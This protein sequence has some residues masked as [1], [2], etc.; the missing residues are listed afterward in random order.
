MSRRQ[1]SSA[2]SPTRST[3]EQPSRSE[4][5]TNWRAA[6]VQRLSQVAARLGVLPQLMQGI[7]PI[8]GAPARPDVLSAVE[9]SLE[10]AYMMVPE[11][12]QRELSKTATQ[13]RD[14]NQKKKALA[15]IAGSSGS[16]ARTT[17]RVPDRTQTIGV[18][19]WWAKSRR[20]SKVLGPTPP[21]E[22]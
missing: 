15:A 16:V 18:P 1:R 7:D 21:T 4:L 10:I 6:D 2:H 20:C 11:Y 22:R 9:R 19:Q 12:R 8:T 17:P 3:T 5:R 14:D 13:Q